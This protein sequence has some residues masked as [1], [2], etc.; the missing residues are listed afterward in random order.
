MRGGEGKAGKAVVIVHDV[1]GWTFPNARLI[2]DSIAKEGYVVYLLHLLNGMVVDFVDALSAIDGKQKGIWTSVVRGVKLVLNAPKAMYPARHGKSP[3]VNV[4]LR[5]WLVP[6]VEHSR[7]A[8]PA[9]NPPLADEMPRPLLAIAAAAFSY[10]AYRIVRRAVS[11][12]VAPPPGS[13]V[14]VTGADAGGIGHALVRAL[15]ADGVRVLAGCFTDGG[16]AA[17]AALDNVRAFRLDV[18]DAASV[19]AMRAIADGECG[20]GGLHAV[21]NVAGVAG[22]VFPWDLAAV[23]SYRRVL[24]VNFLG[25][26]RCTVAVS[27]LLHRAAASSRRTGSLRPKIVVVTS[28][29]AVVHIPLLGPYH[30]SKAAAS[31]FADVVRDEA[32]AHGIDVVEVRPFEVHTAMWEAMKDRAGRERTWWA[33]LEAGRKEAEGVD[34][35]NKY[36]GAE[37]VVAAVGKVQDGTMPLDRMLRP[38][39]VA[40]EIAARLFSNDPEPVVMLAPAFIERVI[41]WIRCHMPGTFMRLSAMLGR[42]FASLLEADG[43]G[44]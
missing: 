13:H 16:V 30:A 5:G 34:P 28:A 31:G 12:P 22:P 39:C 41:Y 8:H 3:T 11:A 25:V 21:C 15:A 37:R 1:L 7:M 10:C 6:S 36:G 14:V 18:T 27:H 44:R 19:A 4:M 32:A 29:N 23:E 9:A 26:V 2:A 17:L 38:E 40:R 42:H 20:D 33:E 24:D 35:A 43:A